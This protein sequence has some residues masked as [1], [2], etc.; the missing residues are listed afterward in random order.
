M[1]LENAARVVLKGLVIFYGR[2]ESGFSGLKA[3]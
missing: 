2:R 1:G 3:V